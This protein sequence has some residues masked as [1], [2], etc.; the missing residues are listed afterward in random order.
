[1]QWSRTFSDVQEIFVLASLG[2]TGISC[3]L[4]SMADNLTISPIIWK[5]G[6]LEH[7][8]FT[9]NI[10]ELGSGPVLV[11]VYHSTN[12]KGSVGAFEHRFKYACGNLNMT[13]ARPICFPRTF[14][15]V[16]N[17]NIQTCLKTY[18]ETQNH[19]HHH[20]LIQP[21][22]QTSHSLGVHGMHHQSPYHHQSPVH[23]EDTCILLSTLEYDEMVLK[24]LQLAEVFHVA[25]VA[26]SFHNGERP[27]SFKE[28]LVPCE[29]LR[30]YLYLVMGKEG[31]L[32][33]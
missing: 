16:H 23:Q 28:N 1:M 13:F 26:L 9:L 20:Q 8:F 6:C 25:I 11:C 7:S 27:L 2:N 17:D 15:C 31:V 10:P 3:M 21:Q 14:Q 12:T 18:P 4:C 32:L 22:C 24:C 30:Y 33:S 29:S 5:G 19:H